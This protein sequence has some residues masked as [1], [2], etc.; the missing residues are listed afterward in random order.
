M[1][2]N[3][4]EVFAEIT[5]RYCAHVASL[6]KYA[7]E[8]DG[9]THSNLLDLAYVFHTCGINIELPIDHNNTQ[10]AFTRMEPGVFPLS[11]NKGIF[12]FNLDRH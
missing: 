8:L 7:T 4:S 6:I 9:R 5:A 1:Q 2:G 12:G 3:C 11:N 10:S